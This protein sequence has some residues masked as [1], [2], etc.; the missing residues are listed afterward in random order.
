MRSDPLQEIKKETKFNFY[1]Y[2]NENYTIKTP[3]IRCFSFIK[4]PS[5]G[6]VHED[7]YINIKPLFG[8]IDPFINI[9]VDGKFIKLIIKTD[10]WTIAEIYCP[11]SYIQEINRENFIEDYRISLTNCQ[12]VRK[13]WAQFDEEISEEIVGICICFNNHSPI[14]IKYYEGIWSDQL[15]VLDFW[16]NI[17]GNVHFK[18][19]DSIRISKDYISAIICE[20]LPMEEIEYYIRTDGKGYCKRKGKKFQVVS[21]FKSLSSENDDIPYIM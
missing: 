20:I 7:A 14:R 12:F 11:I 9:K 18:N 13:N 8:E 6:N 2:K 17:N 21:S 19:G 4:I 15:D 10:A 3:L 5:E 1:L 16:K